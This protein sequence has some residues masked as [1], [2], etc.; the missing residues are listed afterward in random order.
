VDDGAFPPIKHSTD[1]AL[2]VAVLVENA[3]VLDVRVGHV[4]VDG[5]DALQV[6]TFLL[7]GLR[8]DVVMLSGISFGGFNLVDI[9]QLARKTRRPVIAIS[10]DKPHNML[11][12]KALRT[13][14]EDWE[15]R[16]EIVQ[17]AGQLHS[18]KPLRD[19]PRLYFEVRGASP[20][21]A[22]RVIA[23]TAVISRLPEPVRVARI[24]ARGLSD[25]NQPKLP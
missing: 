20:V 17:A 9:S 22:A 11:V 15:E 3:R 4:Q 8:F 14:F 24:L 13:H 16:W 25:L 10:G 12:R 18:T 19:E 7:R 23:S 1:R 2:L 5:R 6:L 21:F